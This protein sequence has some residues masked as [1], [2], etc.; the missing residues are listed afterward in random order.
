MRDNHMF[1]LKRAD[2]S[3]YICEVCVTGGKHVAR[4]DVDT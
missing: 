4:N 3:G 1:D 2:A